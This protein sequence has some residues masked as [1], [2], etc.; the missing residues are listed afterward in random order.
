[1]VASNQATQRVLRLYRKHGFAIRVVDAPR[2]ISCDGNRDDAKEMIAVR[3][4]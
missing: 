3:N 1:V 4:L 2:R